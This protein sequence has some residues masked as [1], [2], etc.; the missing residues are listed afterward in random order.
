MSISQLE[1]RIKSLQVE[2]ERLSKDLETETKNEARYNTALNRTMKSITKYTSPSMLKSKQRSI[3]SDTEKIRRSQKNKL[4]F[5]K[6]SV[7]RKLN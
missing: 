4:K 2:I 1:N 5:R 3:D 7:R 6:R